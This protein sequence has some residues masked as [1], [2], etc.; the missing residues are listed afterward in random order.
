MHANFWIL[1]L[2]V[3]QVTTIHGFQEEYSECRISN[4]DDDS[5]I[6]AERTYR[7]GI[8]LTGL[9]KY[10]FNVDPNQDLWQFIP[11]S[12]KNTFRLRNMKYTNEELFASDN[13]SGMNPFNLKKRRNVYTMNTVHK[14]YDISDEAFE[15]VFKPLESEPNKF[16]ILNKKYKEPLFAGSWVMTFQHQLIYENFEN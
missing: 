5:F 11:T 7:S 1:L 14:N 15:W 6:I 10:A 13:F 16:F 2:I 4:T 9:N 12:R 8:R 3:L